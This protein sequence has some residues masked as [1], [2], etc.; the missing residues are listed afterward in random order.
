VARGP[1]LAAALLAGACTGFTQTPA[2]PRIAHDDIVVQ[3][4]DVRLAARISYPDR[5]GRYPAVVS[6]HGSGR[7]G[8]EQYRPDW[9]R[10]VPEGVAVLTYDKRGVG[11]STGDFVAVGTS[12]SEAYMPLLAADALACLRALRAHPRVDASRVG[13]LGVSQAG[14]L[15]PLAL[16]Q[17]RAGEVAFT[18]IR[19]GP[20][21]SVG[22][23]MEYSR[24]TGEGLRPG[25]GLSPDAMDRRLDAYNGP[26]GLDTVPLLAQLRVPTLWLLGER[27]DSI[28]IRQTQ[29][30]L[31]RAIAAGAPITVRTFPGADHALTVAGRPVP[32]WDD[33]V[34]W[35]RARAILE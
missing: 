13:F 26:H 3:S 17:A 14:W 33:V 30:N 11:E 1:L 2:T 29:Q 16:S 35:L 5:P 32:Y 21:T 6:V 25:E 23:E 34:G 28:P 7:A 19:S 20:A 8:R 18:V 4:G 22:L 24:L 9:Q 10:L 31:A 12:T 15:I 27:D